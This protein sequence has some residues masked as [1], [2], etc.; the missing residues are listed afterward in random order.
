MTAVLGLL[1]ALG[2]IV[3]VPLG[4]RV[5]DDGTQVAL[6]TW[7]SVWPAVGAA[8]AVGLT[9][10]RGGIA[11]GLLAVYAGA[12]VALAVGAVA[13]LV[14]A[15]QN[16]PGAPAEVAVATALLSPAA[17]AFALLARAAG[18]SPGGL[19][20]RDLLALAAALHVAAFGTAL[21]A[22]VSAYAVGNAFSQATALVAAVGIWLFTA[23]L[24]LVGGV[25]LAAA[26]LALSAVLW[27]YG[28][29]ASRTL[30]TKRLLAWAPATTALAALALMAC[31]SASGRVSDVAEATFLTLAAAAS[32]VA[33]SGWRR[34]SLE[35]VAA[36]REE[37]GAAGGCSCCAHPARS[38]A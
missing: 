34:M 19:V 20:D 9:V 7:V 17:G 1:C 4:L 28:R 5:L 16:L 29:P 2:M 26:L 36:S 32:G 18:A 38:P 30:T 23:G 13:R 14:R 37:H 24:P 33:L 6:R 27:R 21:L 12:A 22:G 15:A 11:V 31:V 3:L 25:V 35:R 8:G 10:P